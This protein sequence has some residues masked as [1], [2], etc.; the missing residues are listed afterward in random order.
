MTSGEAMAKMTIN[1]RLG[2]IESLPEP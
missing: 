2:S 1:V